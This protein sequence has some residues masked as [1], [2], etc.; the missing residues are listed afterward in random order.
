[1]AKRRI[2]TLKFEFDPKRAFRKRV[3]SWV[4]DLKDLRWAWPVVEAAI[5]EWHRRVFDSEGSHSLS[6]G[7]PWKPLAEMTIMSRLREEQVSSISNFD[8]LSNN[9]EG[10]EGRILHWSHRLRNAMTSEKGTGDSFRV[11][12]RKSLTY[13][14]KD[15]GYAPLHQKGG[16]N[17]WGKVVPARPFLDHVGGPAVGVAILERALEARMTGGF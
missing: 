14:V 8:Y 11:Y 15:I 2:I 3:R 7:G 12:R 5:V 16:T 1:M 13:G 9:G 4:K 17:R 6:S 10:P